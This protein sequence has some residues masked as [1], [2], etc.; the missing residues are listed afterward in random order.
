MKRFFFGLLSILVVVT[1]NA[2]DKDFF[3][4]WGYDSLVN[5]GV[6]AIMYVVS[7]RDFDIEVKDADKNL[8]LGIGLL[9][10]A[11]EISP[12]KAYPYWWRGIGFKGVKDFSRALM[13]FTRAS[14]LDPKDFK[15][16][17]G[18]AD[19]KKEL[20]DYYGAISD[21]NKAISMTNQS[22]YP[23]Y[24]RLIADR[25]F[26]KLMLQDN[27]NALIDVNKAIELDSENGRYYA[28]KGGV[29]IQ[30]GMKKEGCLQLSKA[31][32]LGF[33]GAYE[34]IASNCK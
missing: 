27:A 7:N 30:L 18:K 5:T 2:Q 26:C 1:S 6:S 24:H 23:P 17:E 8:R 31:G 14:K 9:T 12:D 25:A 28:L 29:L 21:Y 11:I 10:R 34:L 32:E 19:C 20:K 4:K 15:N 16:F 22:K 33:N 3:E 13:D